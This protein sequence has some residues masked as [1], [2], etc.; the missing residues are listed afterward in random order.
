MKNIALVDVAFC[1]ISLYPLEA[2]CNQIMRGWDDWRFRKWISD[3]SSNLPGTRRGQ[4]SCRQ[5]PLSLL[6]PQRFSDGSLKV[7]AHLH[8]SSRAC[9]HVPV[10]KGTPICDGAYW[11]SDWSVFALVFACPVRHGAMPSKHQLTT[12][13]LND[14][15]FDWLDCCH[16]VRLHNA[17]IR[18]AFLLTT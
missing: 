14:S 11:F 4:W 3:I 1:G 13:C 16:L 17:S 6:D 18:T 2:V 7:R 10:H 9:V 12:L 8:A 5:H 15:R